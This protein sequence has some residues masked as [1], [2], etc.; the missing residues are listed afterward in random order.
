MRNESETI[1]NSEKIFEKYNLRGADYHYHQIN[2][3]KIKQYN[4]FVHARY[5]KLIEMIDNYLKAEIKPGQQLFRILDIGCGDGV[6]INLISRKKGNYPF[7]LFGAD[8]SE[9][10]INVARQKNP[11][12]SFYVSEAY[13]LPFNDA[14]FDMIVSS[15]LIEHLKFPEKF[16]NEIKRLAKVNA[17]IMLGTP[18]RFTENPL[19]KM[20][21]KEFFQDEFASLVSKYFNLI[22]ISESHS[23]FQWMQY[24]KRLNFFGLKIGIWRYIYNL[25]SLFGLNPFKSNIKSK[26][27]ISTYMFAICKNK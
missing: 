10:A 21:I 4:A 23:L 8:L 5:L 1:A 17:I 12:S 2:P 3:F 20:H 19:D 14:E 26:S 27:E 9:E 15:D 22:R 13:E 16:L 24:Q 7:E 11:K 6:L 25:K 18:V